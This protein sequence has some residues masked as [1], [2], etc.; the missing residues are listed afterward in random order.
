VNFISE[1]TPINFTGNWNKLIYDVTNPHFVAVTGADNLIGTA[2]NVTT[3][4]KLISGDN[5]EYYNVSFTPSTGALTF[6]KNTSDAPAY[7]HVARLKIWAV[8]AFSRGTKDNKNDT[9]LGD[10]TADPII[11]IPVTIYVK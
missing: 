10:L 7:T 3:Y 8:D 2:V 5:T 11:D 4:A 6:W 9:Q 1:N